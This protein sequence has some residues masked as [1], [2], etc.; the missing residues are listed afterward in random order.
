MKSIRDA[1]A[2]LLPI[3]AIVLG[4]GGLILALTMSRAAS[5][6]PTSDTSLALFSNKQALVMSIQ[7]AKPSLEGFAFEVTSGEKNRHVIK[8]NA[9]AQIVN[10]SESDFPSPSCIL[11][12]IRGGQPISLPQC[13]GATKFTQMLSDRTAFWI[14]PESKRPIPVRILSGN[15]VIGQCDPETICSIDFIP[16]SAPTPVPD[17]MGLSQWSTISAQ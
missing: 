2:L 13:E 8:L 12:L 15:T 9:F 6:N 4:V 17:D 5:N 1:T 16:N 10:L 3:A 11:L 14:D 7:G